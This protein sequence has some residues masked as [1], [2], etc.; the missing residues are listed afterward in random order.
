MLYLGKALEG[1]GYYHFIISV[2]LKKV[3]RM[4]LNWNWNSMD[5]HQLIVFS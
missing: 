2:M 5:V 4:F 3:T 1:N